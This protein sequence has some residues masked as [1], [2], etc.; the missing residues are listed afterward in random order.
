M[1]TRAEM[2]GIPRFKYVPASGGEVFRRTLVD[3]LSLALLAV[4]VI[5]AGSLRLR[6]YP[7]AGS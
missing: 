1:L 2:V 5:I 6:R 4:V 7:V 3:L